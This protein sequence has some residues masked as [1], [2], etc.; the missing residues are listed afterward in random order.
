MVERYQFNHRRM[1]L[2][3]V[4]HGC[5][6]AFEVADMTAF[7]GNDQ[8]AFELSGIGGVDAEVGRQLHRTADAFGDVDEGAI[9]KNGRVEC[10][11]EVVRCR[12]H[13][14]QVLP[15]QF[16]VFLDRF[17]HRAE[18]HPGCCEL[19]LEGRGDRDAVEYCVNSHASESF[20]LIE[21]NTQFLVGLQQFRIHFIQ[22]FGAFLDLGCGVI[23]DALVIDRLV[24]DIGPGRLGHGQPMSIGI[25]PPLQHELGLVFLGRDRANDILIKSRG[26]R[27]GF[28][29]G[30]KARLVFLVDDVFE[31]F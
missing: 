18:D 22:A 9:G 20:L 15:N 10:C 5:G 13:R 4:A 27:V 29:I 6:A 28:K 14:A 17:R 30:D 19:V 12:H 23:A 31:C 16:R 3:F 11:K 25:Q 1:Q 21:R 2:V 26:K 24:I 7:L 8:R